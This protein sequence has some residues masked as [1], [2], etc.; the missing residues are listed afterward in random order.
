MK[1]TTI[2]FV[3]ALFSLVALTSCEDLLE[4]KNYGNPTVDSMMGSEENV[5]LLV[6][7]AYA[8]IKWLHDHC[9]ICAAGCC[10]SGSTV[11]HAV[12]YR[13]GSVV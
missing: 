7:Q 1:K 13:A 4:E 5:V 9:N 12:A 10:R 3:S 6:G 8:D 11:P 2:F